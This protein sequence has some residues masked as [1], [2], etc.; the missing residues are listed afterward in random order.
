VIIDL[1]MPPFT[2]GEI[3]FALVMGGVARGVLVAVSVSA[4]VYC[5]IPLNPYSLLLGLL[6]L[7]L[8]S[9]FLALCGCLA[10]II[11]PS[12]DMLS[13]IT[14]YVITPLA[15]LSGTFYSIQNLPDFW[16]ELCFY[17]PLFYMIDGFRYALTGHHE[18]NIT[19]GITLLLVCDMIL[20]L[21][22]RRCFV[23]G[24]KLRG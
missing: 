23:T 13:A 20:W 17:D 12:F 7:V 5:F 18:G 6:Y 10:G 16:R 3:T 8:A 9:V 15:F 21:V 19:T 11:S 2:G 22:V 1:L 24:W 14:N 4:A